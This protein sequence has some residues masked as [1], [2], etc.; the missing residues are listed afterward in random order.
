[1]NN[2]DINLMNVGTIKSQRKRE[3]KRVSELNIVL[4]SNEVEKPNLFKR[5]LNIFK[6]KRS[7]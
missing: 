1:M 6:F 3:R 5:I 7:S 2:K 4:P